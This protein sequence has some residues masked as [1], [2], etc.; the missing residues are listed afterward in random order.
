MPEFKNFPGALRGAVRFAC[1]LAPMLGL[2]SGSAAQ[3]TSTAEGAAAVPTLAANPYR[4]V[5][6]D[7]G[8]GGKDDGAKWY[9]TAE[10]DLALKVAR[11]VEARLKAHGVP[12][13]MTRS[14]DTFVSLD[15]RA[16]KA[17][18]HSDSIFVSI[19]F[20]AHGTTST[21]GIES[22]YMSESG[23]QLANLIQSKIMGRI[24]TRDRGIKKRNYAVLTRT[25]YTAVLVEGGFISNRWE[26]IRC[27][28][29]WY[30]DELAKAIVEGLLSFR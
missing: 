24:G 21:K 16:A 19:H 2:F 26:C 6:I 18:H 8:H 27:R 10:K 11:K 5:V 7:A 23:R 15:G 20:N 13:L 1:F 9:G 30:Q 28:S 14:D 29:D 17:N 25:K 22:F 4:L 12:T 3:D